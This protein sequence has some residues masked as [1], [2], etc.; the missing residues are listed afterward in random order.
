VLICLLGGLLGSLATLPL[1]GISTGT[2][3]F[4][5]FSEHTFDFRFGFA[6]IFRGVLLALLMGLV[7]GL[8]PAIRAVRM[9]IVSALREQ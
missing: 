8:F 1:N 4:V 2:A 3:N 5:T 7:G 9:Q 6:V